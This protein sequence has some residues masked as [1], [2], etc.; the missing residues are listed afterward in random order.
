MVM[1]NMGT[2]FRKEPYLIVSYLLLVLVAIA[3][4]TSLSLMF[5]S[6]MENE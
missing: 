4:F 3:V 2:K 5:V 1:V 6:R